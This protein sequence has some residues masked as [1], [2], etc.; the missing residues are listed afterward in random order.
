MGSCCS[1]SSFVAKQAVQCPS[2]GTSARPVGRITLTHQVVA[3]LNQQ[4]P[5][6]DF[7]FC[8]SPTCNTVYFSGTGTV[9]E[10]HAVRGEVGQKST[11]LNRPICYC[12][13][14]NLSRVMQETEKNGASASKVFVV[15]R[16]S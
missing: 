12:F 2:C 16:R 8:A 15:D 3:P 4:L 13:D 5:S 10:R 9:I 6:K 11:D 1:S 7:F 14:I